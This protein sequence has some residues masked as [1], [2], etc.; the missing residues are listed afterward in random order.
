VGQGTHLFPV[1]GVKCFVG[2]IVFHGVSFLCLRFGY[3]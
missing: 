1:L 3:S 2:L